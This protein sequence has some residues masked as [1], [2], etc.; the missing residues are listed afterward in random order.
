MKNRIFIALLLAICLIVVTLSGCVNDTKDA[1][2]DESKTKT[3]T[4]DGEKPEEAK[5][6]EF[7]HFWDLSGHTTED[8]EIKLE[9][10]KKTN[11]KVTY[12]IPISDDGQKLNV[13]MA[14]GDLPDI[15]TTNRTNASVQTLISS[16]A[17][18]SLN[19]LIDEYAP[20]LWVDV[21]PEYYKFHKYKDGKN[22]YWTNYIYTP[23]VRAQPDYPKVDAVFMSTSVRTDIWE[24]IG[25][26]D[27]S[28]PDKYVEMLRMVK[29]ANPDIPTLYFTGFPQNGGLFMNS[30]S[31]T[32]GFFGE[33]GI[34]KYSVNS[35]NTTTSVIRDPKFFEMVTWMNYL[36]NEGLLDAQSFI[37]DGDM[38]KNKIDNGLVGVFHAAIG[39]HVYPTPDIGY[40]PIP[41][42]E[43]MDSKFS[44]SGAGWLATMV[45]KSSEEVE[46]VMRWIAYQASTEGRRLVS[47]G[48]EDRHWVWNPEKEGEPIKTDI[49][50][51]ME[52]SSDFMKK[53]GFWQNRALH[54]QYYCNSLFEK[55]NEERLAWYDVYGDAMVIDIFDGVRNP[56]LDE[57]DL[58][59]IL[60]K[61]NELAY[62]SYPQLIMAESNVELKQIYD[63]FVAKADELGLEQLEEAW[64]EKWQLFDQES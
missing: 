6:S 18:Y 25:K 53:W 51:N 10:E 26:P 4:K 22:Y 49:W 50:D 38:S 56:P 58:G 43:D 44:K 41:F 42:F 30:D 2:K 1:A 62:T 46:G 7:E 31:P 64:T 57:S 32:Y 14:S 47:W 40:T 60:A 23:F 37:D 55:W 28:T 33:W 21:E 9:L 8:T 24:D 5:V 20:S 54:D 45:T 19:E 12:T 34:H 3:E 59:M 35:D 29:A 48:I 39:N 61:L 16:D 15:I 63:D 27:V 17:V 13:M 36:Y 11:T 52:D